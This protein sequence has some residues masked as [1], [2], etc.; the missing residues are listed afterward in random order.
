MEEEARRREEEEKKRREEEERQYYAELERQRLEAEHAAKLAAAEEEAKR[1][2]KEQLKQ[3][4]KSLPKI[5]SNRVLAAYDSDEELD[6]DTVSELTNQLYQNYDQ[7]DDLPEGWEK[8]IDATK[9]IPYYVN[10][11]T[12]TSQ[13]S[14]PSSPAGN[15]HDDDKHE[16]VKVISDER[17]LFDS[18]SLM[19]NDGSDL[20]SLTD[21]HSHGISRRGQLEQADRQ[22]SFVSIDGDND[23]NNS[24]NNNDIDN[25]DKK[26]SSTIN[27]EDV[28]PELSSEKVLQSE[29]EPEL[30]PVLRKGILQKQGGLFGMW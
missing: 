18:L 9:N 11:V 27:I 3:S 17:R 13:W 10:T 6:A 16:D 14:R 29:P 22:A 20:T 15:I 25:E 7:L 5:V 23:N 30:D 28:K 1:I 24:N 4:Q 2:L 26:I 21:E 12:Q 19:S 8:H